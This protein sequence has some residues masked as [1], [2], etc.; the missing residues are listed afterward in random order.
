MSVRAS[1]YICNYIYK[2]SEIQ[3]KMIK[4]A[5]RITS[6]RKTKAQELKTDNKS[7]SISD[8]RY[9]SYQL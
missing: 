8:Y 3:Q 7:G 1:N 9:W 2:L 6:Q 4:Y 5:T